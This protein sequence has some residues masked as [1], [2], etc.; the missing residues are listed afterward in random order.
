MTFGFGVQGRAY[1]SQVAKV[2]GEAE[3]RCGWC[4]VDGKRAWLADLKQ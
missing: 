4:E 3:K 2:V 1:K